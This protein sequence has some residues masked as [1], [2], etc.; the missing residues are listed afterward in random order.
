MLGGGREPSRS[1]EVQH[2]AAPIHEGQ[3]EEGQHKVGNRGKD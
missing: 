1:R 3:A 2:G